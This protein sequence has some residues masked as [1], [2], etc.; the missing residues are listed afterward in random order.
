[1]NINK[2]IK[3]GLFVIVIFV[4]AITMYAWPSAKEISA[5]SE[6]MSA[7]TLNENNTIID[8]NKTVIV[9]GKPIG[10]YV[11]SKGIMVI[12]TGELADE[13]GNVCA[14]SKDA[15]K[16]G[17]YIISVNGV[18]VHDKATLMDMIEASNG[19]SVV[20]DVIR[21][22]EQ[23]SVNVTPVETVDGCYR[24]GAWVKDDIAG[25][26]TLTYVDGEKFGAL[27]HSINDNDTG[28]IFKLSDGAIYETNII[29]IVKAS[30][31]APGRLEGVIDYSK[32]C[33]LG[34][35]VNNDSYG[36][37]G[38]LI[39]ND[40]IPEYG[41]RMPIADKT[42]VRPGKAYIYSCISGKGDFY[43]INIT[44]INYAASNEGKNMKLEVVDLRLL[45]ETNGIVQGMSGSP[46]IQDG[47][48]IGAVTHVFVNNPTKGYGIFIENMI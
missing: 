45:E 10:I 34:R 43:E 28:E 29:N 33:Q 15:L 19:E 4:L 16:R 38:R 11:K 24:M 39:D 9:S 3:I 22:D 30:K 5:Y 12:G 25:I 20:L 17:D 31:G 2:K 41:I 37:N 18:D 40:Y 42:A 48:L 27:G 6:D 23:L 14:P 36:I 7:D 35:I 47:H 8:D 26:G 46:I 44:D 32:G 1:M 21:N 13:S